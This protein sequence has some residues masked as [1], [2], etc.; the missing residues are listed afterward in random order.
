MKYGAKYL[1]WAKI[2]ADSSEASLPTYEG[3]ISLGGLQKVTD[4]PNFN[5]AKGGSDDRTS[6]YIK[7][8]ADAGVD[9]EIDELR[10]EVA[11]KVLGATID[12]SDDLHHKIDDNGPAGGLAFYTSRMVNRQ[13]KYKCVFYPSLIASMVGEEFETKGGAGA[14]SI[15]LSGGKMSF[16]AMGSAS[17]DWKIESALLDTEAAAKAW[18]DTK[19]P[20]PQA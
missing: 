13:K 12:S 5:E 19:L 9:V 4:S 18:V 3:S 14:G 2:T 7:E 10:D 16:L 17:R 15:T 1:R 6:E 8:F 11:E 20:P